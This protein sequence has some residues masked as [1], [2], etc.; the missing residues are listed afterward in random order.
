MGNRI[1]TYATSFD[2][3]SHRHPNLVNVGKVKKS[4]KE[5][6]ASRLKLL[7]HPAESPQPRGRH[8]KNV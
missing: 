2:N 6:M 5:W 4:N 3:Q 8:H 7:T 1:L